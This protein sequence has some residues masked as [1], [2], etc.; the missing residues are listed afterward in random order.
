MTGDTLAT[1]RLNE[2]GGVSKNQQEEYKKFI[3]DYD[4]A[5]TCE[6]VGSTKSCYYKYV[7]IDDKYY[8]RDTTEYDENEFCHDCCVLNEKGKNMHHGCC[9]DVKCAAC[10]EQFLLD[11]KHEGEI[12][13]LAE[14]PKGTKLEED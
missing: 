5:L 1:D 11:V 12:E 4:I 14:L 10:G 8:L 9:C 13:S 3:R 6:R 2:L 7:K